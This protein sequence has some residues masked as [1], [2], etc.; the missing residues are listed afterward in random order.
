MRAFVAVVPISTQRGQALG[1]SQPEWRKN[2]F[3][4]FNRFIRIRGGWQL[5]EASWYAANANLQV[6]TWIEDGL[7]TAA[8]Q[9]WQ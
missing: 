4:H 2:H 5:A 8:G 6:K 3:P 9:C 1:F 7:P